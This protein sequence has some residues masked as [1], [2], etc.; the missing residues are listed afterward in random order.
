MI[1]EMFDD[2]VNFFKKKRKLTTG[3]VFMFISLLIFTILNQLM[4]QLG[5]V[6]FELDVEP[7]LAVVINYT[8]LVTGYFIITA[9]CF[10]PFRLLGGKRLSD[11]FIITSYSMV[12]LALFWIPHILPQAILTILSMILMTRGTAIYAKTNN[13]KAFIIT[14]SFIALVV[15]FSILARNY[16]LLYF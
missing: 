16:I 5:F 13:R 12:P 14:A 1:T 11:I 15:I 10:L 8:S 7:Y 4:I 2:P 3:I 9:I 6:K